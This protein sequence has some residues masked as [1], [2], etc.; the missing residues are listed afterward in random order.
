MDVREKIILMLVI[1]NFFN[2]KDLKLKSHFLLLEPLISYI[3]IDKNYH[4]RNEVML[5]FQNFNIDVD[6]ID[7]FLEY[8][9]NDN[10]IMYDEYQDAY[11]LTLDSEIYKLN[12]YIIE[13]QDL[14]N[15]LKD[16][17]LHIATK[18]NLK[19]INTIN[20]NE[21][22]YNFFNNLLDDNDTN[23]SLTDID[24]EIAILIEELRTLNEEKYFY[25]IE[26]I[27]HGIAII[28]AISHNK[29]KNKEFPVIYLDNIFVGNILGWCNNIRHKSSILILQH[30]QKDGFII[31]VHKETLEIIYT[32]IKKY[33]KALANHKNI[34]MG[35]FYYYL[36]YLDPNN[37]YLNINDIPTPLIKENII[38][39][40]KE[41]N[42]I[43]NN[44]ELGI[45]VDYQDA[46]YNTIS[47]VRNDIY[48]NTLFDSGE[49]EIRPSEEQTNYDYIIIKYYEEEIKKN[50][51]SQLG[52]IKE[53]FLTY[54]KAI[55]ISLPY[56]QNE[57]TYS[58]IMWIKQFFRIII[59]DNVL[60][61]ININTEIF[62]TIIFEYCNNIMSNELIVKFNDIINN[63]NISEENKKLLLA[64]AAD[65]DNWSNLI[66]MD[67]NEIVEKI[68]RQNDELEELKE[69]NI[70][71]EKNIKS[72]ENEINRIKEESKKE[73]ET[74]TKLYNDNIKVL[75]DE[76]ER[77][78][79]ENIRKSDNFKIFV[80]YIIAI[81]ISI[82]SYFLKKV[83]T[84][85]FNSFVSHIVTSLSISSAVIFHFV[86]KKVIHKK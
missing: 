41:Y 63:Q 45:K 79:D 39:R 6:I 55:L 65:V 1:S 66:N 46:I 33:K 29:D 20:F 47:S 25:V 10:I 5:F 31:K 8:F 11:R 18:N 54:Q 4:K 40:L 78:K 49:I 24:L 50:L 13:S 35:T 30:L 83:L 58:N 70:K 26:H 15:N 68:K 51:N 76:I 32:A 72:L 56:K 3:L 22:F 64:Y 57:C 61:N 37:K 84:V 71:Y 81:F 34:I 73:K 23:N 36:K 53:I 16:H 42:I 19:N 77:I 80:G 7:S 74:E 17:S 14:W 28:K 67:P 38:L 9:K 82:A 27:M 75:K 59:L 21:I 86:I 2:K 12:T 69:K 48:K 52:S 60:S 62:R 43:V 85:E 44:D